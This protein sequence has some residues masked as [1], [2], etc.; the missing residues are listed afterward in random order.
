MTIE[1]RHAT[2]SRCD[3]IGRTISVI[4]GVVIENGVLKTY[5]LN[6]Y[7]GR[8]LGMK[9]TGNASRGVTGN[10]SVG[11]GNL[12]LKQGLDTAETIVRSVRQGLYVTELI[13][14]GGNT[15]TGDYSL[16]AAGMWIENGEF[17]YP[18]SEI[19]I[20]G[21]LREM[22]PN[23]ASIGSDLEFRGS[24]AAPTLMIAQMTIS[25]Q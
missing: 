11:H 15:V 21:N 10:A 3:F 14:S 1:F 5:L 4:V 2:V 13:G 7:T 8:K 16:G 23:I 6:S 22:L 19:T 18:V 9:T 17:A 24:V 20:A 12:F 25:G